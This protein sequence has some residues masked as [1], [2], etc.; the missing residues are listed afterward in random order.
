MSVIGGKFD[1]N[2]WWGRRRRKGD[3]LF[4]CGG[5]FWILHGL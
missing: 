3:A 5:S 1:K 4:Q 2:M